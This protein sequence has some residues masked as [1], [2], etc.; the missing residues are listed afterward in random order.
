MCP[1][2]DSSAVD[3]ASPSPVCRQATSRGA[4]L[5]TLTACLTCRL[6][7]MPQGHKLVRGELPG[8][9]EVTQGHMGSLWAVP[10]IFPAQLLMPGN[11]TSSEPQTCHSDQGPFSAALQRTCPGLVVVLVYVPHRHTAGEL[12]PLQLRG[13]GVT[14]SYSEPDPT[15]WIYGV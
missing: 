10:S 12:T 15:E 4:V 13:S 1:A 11:C 14:P 5:L 9:L 8:L 3:F 2:C 6:T 7:A